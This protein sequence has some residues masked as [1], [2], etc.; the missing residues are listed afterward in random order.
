[1]K[2][3]PGKFNYVVACKYQTGRLGSYA[4]FGEVQYGDAEDAASMLT[5]VKEQ[6]PDTIWD[7]YP[8][9]VSK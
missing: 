4:Y 9:K 8:I 3:P 6:S 7:I 5:Y 1:M 2:L